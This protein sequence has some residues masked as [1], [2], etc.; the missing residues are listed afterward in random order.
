[1]KELNPKKQKDLLLGQDTIDKT[2][3][4]DN[5]YESRELAQKAFERSKEKLFDVHSW[6]SLPG[7]TSSF[8][9]YDSMGVKKESGR[10]EEGD[11][12]KI[13]LPG[14]VPENWVHITEVK[15]LD[16]QAWFT[17]SPSIDPTGPD[18]E[19]IEHFFIKEATSTFKVVL[20]DKHISAHEI[21]KKEGINNQGVEA[22]KRKLINT[23]ISEGGWLGF[24]KL[25]WQKLTDYLVHKIEIEE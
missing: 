2:F 24:Q 12:M 23:L 6:S 8:L 22:G 16:R 3:S 10:P 25:Q 20:N 19:K 21:G 18:K 5:A 7:T 17:T 13:I 11:Y 14:P 4:S 15:D 1:M 9:L